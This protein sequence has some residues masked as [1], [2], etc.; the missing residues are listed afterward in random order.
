MGE[1]VNINHR[2]S[3]TVKSDLTKALVQLIAARVPVLKAL[4]LSLLWHFKVENVELLDEWD[5]L[6]PP[7]N[8]FL[9]ENAKGETVILREDDFNKLSYFIYYMGSFYRH[10]G[11]QDEK[12]ADQIFC[13]LCYYF[14]KEYVGYEAGQEDFNI[15]DFFYKAFPKK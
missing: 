4:P 1:L 8:S 5:K 13:N 6:F 9:E 14:L 3:L 15:S 11:D 7:L 2:P 10:S 12:S